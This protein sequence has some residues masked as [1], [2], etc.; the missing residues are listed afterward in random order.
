VLKQFR[1]RVLLADEVGLGKT[2]EAGMVFKEY[3]LRGMAERVL[4]L[5]PASLIGQWR[6]ELESKFGL[7]CAT[8]HDP[9]LREDP[10]GFWA[11]NR[12]IASISAQWT[13]PKTRKSSSVMRSLS[14][15]VLEG[16]SRRVRVVD[17][18]LRIEL[19]C[20]RRGRGVEVGPLQ[21]ELGGEIGPRFA[22]VA[23]HDLQLGKEPAHLVEQ[24]GLL[25]EHRHSRARHGSLRIMFPFVSS[26]EQ[27]REDALEAI[28]DEIRHLL[29]EGVV[30]EAKDV[31]TALLLGAGWPFWLGGITK[32]LDQTGVSEKMFGRPLAEVGAGAPT[33]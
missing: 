1:G 11:E 16:L 18:V 12:I 22:T 7:A 9:R 27:I 19:R 33:A 24:L 29:E 15:E 17:D 20:E 4:V 32:Y 31:D 10:A 8:T 28:A 13:S 5:T 2:V 23:R 30:A 26:V 3:A 6:E 25:A 21:Q 14:N